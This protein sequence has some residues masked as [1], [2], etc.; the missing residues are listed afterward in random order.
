VL[1]ACLRSESLANGFDQHRE[2]TGFLDDWTHAEGLLFARG[3]RQAAAE[4][5]GGHGLALGAQVSQDAAPGA[6]RHLFVE[7]D[8]VERALLVKEAEG[9]AAISGG[10]DIEARGPETGDKETAQ[11]V[12]I[13]GYED[14]RIRRSSAEA[15]RECAGN[16]RH[17]AHPIETDRSALSASLPPVWVHG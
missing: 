8:Q 9:F 14:A 4:Q 10:D 15:R 1:H 13:V 2:A 7:Q 3:E 16:K 11:E 17:G 6:F 5:Q 12:V